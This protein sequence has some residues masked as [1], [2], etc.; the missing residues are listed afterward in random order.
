M[1]MFSWSCLACGFSLRDCRNCS[2]DSWMGHGVALSPNGTRVIGGYDGYGRLGD[3]YNL[4]DQMGDFSVYHKAC[5]ELVGK[6]DFTKASHQAHDQGFCH[7]MHGQPF[8]L[9]THVWLEKCAVWHGLDR[10]IQGAWNR[11]YELKYEEGEALFATLP[12]DAQE[13]ALA[14]FKA[15]EA[16]RDAAYRAAMD[17]YY[18]SDDESARAPERPEKPETFTFEGVDYYASV[19]WVINARRHDDELRKNRKPRL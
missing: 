3:T 2:V 1:G 15:D 14:A 16:A 9:P 12:E 10:A 4:A 18:K 5:W 19:L 8:P 11:H 7:A 6:P 17:A 13:R